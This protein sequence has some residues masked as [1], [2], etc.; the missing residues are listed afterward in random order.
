LTIRATLDGFEG[1]SAVVAVDGPEIVRLRL[2]PS[3]KG[4]V[5][6]RVLPAD[7]VV[8]LDGVK[9]DMGS[10]GVV[11]GLSVSVGTHR[12]SVR[13]PSGATEERFFE[14]VAGETKN[15]RT[16]VVHSE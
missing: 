8:S 6:F 16:I 15:L 14:V 7:S 2:T 3:A 5:R 1:R 11:V 4:E 13:A 10:G 9:V 12:L